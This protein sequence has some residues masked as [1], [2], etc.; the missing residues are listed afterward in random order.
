MVQPLTY[1][2]GRVAPIYNLVLVVVVIILFVHLFNTPRKKTYIKP[3]KFL[4]VA[5]LIFVVEEIITV[6]DQAAVIAVPK[7]VFPLLEMVII[8][9]FIYMLLLQREYVKK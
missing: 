2:I 1:C 3:W 4:F 5:V 6:L 8:T 9:A 7:I